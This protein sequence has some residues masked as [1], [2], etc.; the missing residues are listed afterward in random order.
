ML[1]LPSLHCSGLRLEVSFG[2]PHV[3]DSLVVACHPPFAIFARH[4]NVLPLVLEDEELVRLI[5]E[6]RLFILDHISLLRH[7]HLVIVDLVD[8]I[9]L[10]CQL[11]LSEATDVYGI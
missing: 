5:F 10:S 9:L 7:L 4:W 6:L 11:L 3:D 2:G 1:V 8:L